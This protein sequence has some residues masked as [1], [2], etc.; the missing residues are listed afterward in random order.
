MKPVIDIHEHIFR[1][2][3]IPLEGYLLSR[4]YNFIIQFLGR[5]NFF[6]LIAS[7]IRGGSKT[8][9]K[10][11]CYRLGISIATKILGGDYKTWAKI[12]SIDKIEDVTSLMIKTFRK[13]RID[14]YV[15]LVL[16]YEY[17]FKNTRD[18]S[19]TEQVEII[20]EMI[21]E[22]KGKI[23]PFIPFD[24]ARELAF[25]KGLPSP[26]DLKKRKKDLKREQCSSLE[27]VKEAIEKR[28]FIGVKIYN[29]LGYRPLGNAAVDELR[30]E[31]I[32]RA[33]K[34]DVYTAFKGEEFDQVLTELY[35]Y[36]VEKEVPIT[37][38]CFTTEG[39]EAY[40]GASYDFGDPSCWEE[41]LKKYPSLHLN[42]AHFGWTPGESYLA[43]KPGGY[44]TWVKKIC[45]LVKKHQYVFVDVSQHEVVVP[46]KAKLMESD[47]KAIEKKYPSLLQKSLMFGIDWHVIS[48]VKGFRDF[49]N[50]YVELLIDNNIFSEN[51]ID[52]FLGGNAL[53]FLGLL[54]V[55]TEQK[56]GWSQNRERLKSFYKTNHIEPPEWFASAEHDALKLAKPKGP[57]T[58]P[59]PTTVL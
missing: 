34:M 3:D 32:F 25:R 43:K 48:R 26:D 50:R 56:K 42:L 59:I 58:R 23:H 39:T 13:D 2:K 28:G 46:K 36:C 16:D 54:P 21:K 24:P 37:A 29:A 1:G 51:E 44:K 38:H 57:L 19:I 22:Y 15:P 49:K 17:W 6:H 52:D 35:E 47:Y 45:E 40:P 5:L 14:L 11:I 53:R 30:N 18:K 55:G 41:V 12:L 4:K 9:I 27:L 8:G 7:C 31:K 10:G 33:N 20:S